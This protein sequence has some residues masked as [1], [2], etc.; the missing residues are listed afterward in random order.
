V[1]GAL[2]DANSPEPDL[3]RIASYRVHVAAAVGELTEVV[4][5][6]LAAPLLHLCAVRLA[7]A[8]RGA[9]ARAYLL[10]ERTL[11]GLVRNPPAEPRAEAR[12]GAR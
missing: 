3:R 6:R 12:R 5:A 8:D 2:P 1:L 10:W 9:E 4:R 7:G 11:E